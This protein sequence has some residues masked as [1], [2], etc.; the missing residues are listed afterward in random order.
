MFFFELKIKDSKGSK[1]GYI[2]LFYE[3][4]K[5]ATT[6]IVDLGQETFFSFYQ[7]TVTRIVEGELIISC[8]Q[9]FLNISW[10]FLYRL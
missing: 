6:F 8:I 1:K 2:S 5:N 10:F 9:D 3:E 4:F 7:D